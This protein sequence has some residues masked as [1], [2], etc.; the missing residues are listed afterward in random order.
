MNKTEHVPLATSPPIKVPMRPKEE[1]ETI[2]IKP[3]KTQNS[4]NH[5]NLENED[6]F[7]KNKPKLSTTI[8]SLSVYSTVDDND[9]TDSTTNYFT[10]DFNS[11]ITTDD[12][13]L[14]F[15]TTIS[16]ENTTIISTTRE[17][18]DNW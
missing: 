14:T 16:D 1:N 9:Y 17:L 7:L 4:T 12:D 3:N 11:N 6:E 15:T 10:T 5:S 8:D 13:S 2:D 18:E